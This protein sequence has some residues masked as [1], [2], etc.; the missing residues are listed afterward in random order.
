M[1]KLP[2]LLVSVAVVR[3]SAA[4]TTCIV[5]GWPVA[6]TQTAV[7]GTVQNIVIGDVFKAPAPLA[8]QIDTRV[9]Y[10]AFAPIDVLDSRKLGFTL[11]VK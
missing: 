6:G 2:L 10:E 1:K 7:T 8:C 4:A 11:I 5:G 3:L 9:L